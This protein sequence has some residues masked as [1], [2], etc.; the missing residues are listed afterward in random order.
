[1]PDGMQYRVT[2]F[3]QKDAIEREGLS[4]PAGLC[5]GFSTEW[6]NAHRA[7]PSASAGQ[8]CERL[9]REA[10]VRKAAASQARFVNE[11]QSN[12][13]FIFSDAPVDLGSLTV[14]RINGDFDIDANIIRELENE[15]GYTIIIFTLSRG[16]HACSSIVRNNSLVFF[17]P[18][19]GEFLVPHAAMRDFIMF[20]KE[21]Y[22]ADRDHGPL[23]GVLLVRVVARSMCVIA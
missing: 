1:M 13:G 12:P 16:S 2:E 11:L 4:A 23:A 6:I 21:L 19:H 22:N 17:D 9:N 7:A 14:S 18:N 15:G 8:R 3:K 5:W 10:H 20:V